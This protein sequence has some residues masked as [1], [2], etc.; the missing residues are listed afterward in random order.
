MMRTSLSG[1]FDGTE[2]SAYVQVVFRWNRP[3]DANGA[4]FAIG[5]DLDANR[6]LAFGESV[7]IRIQDGRYGFDD[8]NIG[9]AE[10]RAI[11]AAGQSQIGTGCDS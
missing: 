11:L 1:P 9:P 2:T 3:D 4:R 5:N 8:A 10:T 7:A 6:A